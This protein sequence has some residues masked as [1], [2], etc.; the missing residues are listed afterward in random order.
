MVTACYLAVNTNVPWIGCCH[1]GT[2]TPRL[3]APNSNYVQHLPA[4]MCV[5][6]T[7]NPSQ[8]AHYSQVQAQALAK[9]LTVIW[10]LPYPNLYECKHLS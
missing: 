6:M 10:T 2:N 3:M 4:V 7:I 5:T 1:E 8:G 9:W